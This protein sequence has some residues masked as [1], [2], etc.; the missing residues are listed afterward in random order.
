MASHPALA[1]KTK[2]RALPPAAAHVAAEVTQPVSQ[3]LLL[4]HFS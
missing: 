1:V 3:T 2:A 4:W